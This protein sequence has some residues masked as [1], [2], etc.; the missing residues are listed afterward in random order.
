M[1]FAIG[2][3]LERKGMYSAGFFEPLR[4]PASVELR[5]RRR[6]GDVHQGFWE[7]ASR[8]MAC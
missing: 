8:P 1:R 6:V 4:I 3:F 5:L 7:G 2:G